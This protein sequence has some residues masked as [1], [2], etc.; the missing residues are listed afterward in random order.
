MRGQRTKHQDLNI[1]ICLILEGTS[2]TV[3]KEAA[4]S[5]GDQGSIP[6]SGR[7]TGKK[8]QPTPVFLPGESCKERSLAGYSSWSSKES[9]MTEVT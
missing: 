9:N 2:G 5:A 4:C 3:G 8:W 6:G 1:V 7:S